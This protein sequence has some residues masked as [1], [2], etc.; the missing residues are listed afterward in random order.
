MPLH[1]ADIAH[2]LPLG[3]PALDEEHLILLQLVE[4]LRSSPTEAWITC[5]DDLAQHA[6]RH[7]EQED[8]DLR[9][10]GGEAI[11][12]HLDEHAAVMQSLADVRQALGQAKPIGPQELDMIDRLV[13]EFFRWLPEHVQVMDA[14][15]AH[16][17]SKRR[18]G[19][20]PILIKKKP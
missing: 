9:A 5:L 12:C 8:V 1:R 15:V 17:R 14:T 7:F 19:G 20:A 18:L 6:R 10:I 16:Y 4:R 11:Q 2:Q 3:E 13:E